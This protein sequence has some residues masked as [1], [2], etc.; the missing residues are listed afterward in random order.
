MESDNPCSLIVLVMVQFSTLEYRSCRCRTLLDACFFTRSCA[1][2][3]MKAR[4]LL[5]AQSGSYSTG[6]V[7]TYM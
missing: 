7:H 3:T 6:A 2:V 1:P 5:A 4:E